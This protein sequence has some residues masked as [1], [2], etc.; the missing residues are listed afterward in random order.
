MKVKSSASVDALRKFDIFSGCDDRLLKKLSN[1]GTPVHIETGGALT[2]EGKQGRE[3][4]L[5][6]EGEAEV[7]HEG[8]AIATLRG[9]DFFGE[10]SLI[11]GLP[12]SADVVA[13]TPMELIVFDPREF[14]SLLND[15]P[16]VSKRILRTM[17]L[18]LRAAQTDTTTAN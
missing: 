13:S 8:K 10:M 7:R 18:R 6:S 4:Y 16:T 5:I 3:F 11:D 14:S 15:Y 1:L 2:R 9:G 17:T 12:R